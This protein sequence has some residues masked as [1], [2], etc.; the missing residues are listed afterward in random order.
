MARMEI[1]SPPVTAEQLWA[2]PDDGPQDWELVR[3]VLRPVSASGWEHSAEGMRLAYRLMRWVMEHRLG[4][5]TG[6]DGGYVLQRDPDTVY[7]PDVGFLASDRLPRGPARVKFY[8]GAPDLAAEVLSPGA[9]W[10][11][12]MEKV[13]DSLGAGTRMVLVVDLARRRMHVFR[14]GPD[15]TVLREDDV[16]DASDV[17]AGWQLPLRELFG[18]EPAPHPA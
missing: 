11:P 1:G 8:E 17:V 12:V 16:L 2:M 4:T 5:V 9:R 6:A 14:P 15:V 7:A 10:S 3:G 13:E 18:D